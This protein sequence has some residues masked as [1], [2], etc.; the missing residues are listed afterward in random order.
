MRSAVI[1]STRSPG[2]EPGWAG[3]RGIDRAI[4]LEL[5]SNVLAE[6]ASTMASAELLAAVSEVAASHLALTTVVLFK[7][8]AGQSRTL[9]WAAPGVPAARR[10]AA[11]EHAWTS[12]AELMDHVLYDTGSS[13][14]SQR[15]GDTASV[16]IE[17][18]KLG[19][20]V[21]LYVESRRALDGPD[22]WLLGEILRRMVGMP[23]TGAQ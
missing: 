14:R 4:V 16:S 10:L 2:I 12:A 3:F 6:G 1:A 18:A 13:P 11:R 22:R 19:L 8:V 20:S 21:M 23:G 15:G 5:V 17:D 9:A 7:R